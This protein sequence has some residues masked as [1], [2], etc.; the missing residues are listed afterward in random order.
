MD[1]VELDLPLVCVLCPYCGRALDS[2]GLDP[3]EA[4]WMHEYECAGIALASDG[5][6]TIH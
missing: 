1:T 6:I 5:W 2:D 4:L 3:L